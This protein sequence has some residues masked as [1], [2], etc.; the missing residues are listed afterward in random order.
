MALVFS[1]PGLFLETANQGK[2]MCGR[3]VLTTYMGLESSI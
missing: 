3:A 2:E 1:V